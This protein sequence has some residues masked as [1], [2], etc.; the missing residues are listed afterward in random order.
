MKTVTEFID[1]EYKSYAKYVLE[2]R[3]IPSVCDGFKPSQRKIMYIANK[4]CTSKKMKTA[5]LSGYVI[6]KGNG[7]KQEALTLK[8][9]E[10]KITKMS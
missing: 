10:N 2:S 8:D 4:T 9:N 1:N 6:A 7:K 3:A 5:A